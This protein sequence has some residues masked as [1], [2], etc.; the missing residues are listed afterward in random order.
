MR[1]KKLLFAGLS[2]IGIG[3][4]AVSAPPVTTIDSRKIR[5]TMPTVAADDLQFEMPTNES[6][7]GAPQFHEDEWRQLEFYPSSR[8]PELQSRLKEYKTFEQHN[9][10][11]NGWKDI[12]SRRISGAPILG[13]TGAKEVASLLGGQY[14]PS[15]ILTTSSAAL[16]Q[17]KGGFT[18]RL[19][20]TVFL[21]GL[22]P[23]ANVTVLSAVV[24]RGGDDQALTTAFTSLHRQFKV[25][26][27]DWRSQMVLVDVKHDD[28]VEVWRP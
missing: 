17:V 4:A 12:Y 1:F 8:L 9:R 6:F 3:N 25:V 16:G 13:A 23:G 28:R 15:P 26:L 7:Q 2:A 19:N 22:A 21:Y 24:E 18:V 27:V 10:T 5:F 11:A 20:S 14:Q